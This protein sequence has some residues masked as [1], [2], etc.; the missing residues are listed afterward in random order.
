MCL[1]KSAEFCDVSLVHY[2]LY[3]LFKLLTL[4]TCYIDGA[5]AYI[6]FIKYCTNKIPIVS[7]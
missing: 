7:R 2:K 5:M 1:V 4:L 6:Y 3:A